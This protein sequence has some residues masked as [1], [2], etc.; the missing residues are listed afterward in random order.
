[1]KSLT[2]FSALMLC[3]ALHTASPEQSPCG[4]ADIGPSIPRDR[5]TTGPCEPFALGSTGYRAVLLVSHYSDDSRQTPQFVTISVEKPWEERKY[6]ICFERQF[7]AHDVPQYILSAK[8]KDVVAYDDLTRVVSFD[9]GTAHF[10][11]GLPER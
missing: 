11:Y 1:M 3:V 2:V 4:K 6:A 10:D 5:A 7:R 9:L 8:T